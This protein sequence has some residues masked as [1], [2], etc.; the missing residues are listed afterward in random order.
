MT[1]DGKHDNDVLRKITKRRMTTSRLTG[2]MCIVRNTTKLYVS[3][4]NT[5]VSMGGVQLLM[6]TSFGHCLKA[7][8]NNNELR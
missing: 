4:S 1:I 6:A 8:K 3:K 2:W 7:F 5:A